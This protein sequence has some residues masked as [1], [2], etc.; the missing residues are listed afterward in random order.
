M[1]PCAACGELFAA[2]VQRTRFCNHACYVADARQRAGASL[3][4][5]FWAKVKVRDTDACWLWAAAQIRGYGQFHAGR[6]GGKNR[7][8]YAHR[9]AWTMTHGTIPDNL[10]VLHRC[11]TPLCVNPNHLFLGTQADNLADA[12]QKGRLVDGRHLTKV[13][14]A[15]V[16]DIQRSYQPRK[17]GR[18]LATKYGITL[19]SVMRIAKGTQRVDPMARVFQ[20]VPHVNREVRGEVA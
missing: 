15:G 10:S 1:V 6:V 9:F 2:S 19:A 17:N 13:S 4:A 11:D 14:A 20:R 7:T 16:A 12:R 18:A 3:I 8:V 5:R